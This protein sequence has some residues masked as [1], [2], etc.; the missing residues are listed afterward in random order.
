M[1]S[2]PAFWLCEVVIKSK[3][4]AGD[5][6]LIGSALTHPPIAVYSTDESDHKSE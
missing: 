1:D 2:Q 3:M 4:L 5:I 6:R